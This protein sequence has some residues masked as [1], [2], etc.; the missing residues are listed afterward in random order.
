MSL[1][2][3][4]QAFSTA[5]HPQTDG[6]TE[7]VNRVMQ[8]V[9]RHYVNP[10][11]DDWDVWLPC[12]EFAI[13]NA[14]HS[15]SKETPFF[16]NYGVHPSTPLSLQSPAQ[17]AAR[18]QLPAALKFTADMHAAL[19]RAKR[20]LQAAQDRMRAHADKRRTELQLQVG[21]VVW[22][23]S[24]N[25]AVKHTGSRKL[26]PRRLGPFT[27]VQCINPVAYKLALPA[28]MSKVHPVFH[29]SLLTPYTDG[30]RVQ[31]APAPVVLAD[32]ALDYEVEAVIGHR[33]VGR[34]R[35]L[36]YLIKFKGYG[37][38]HNEWLP[39]ANL[40]CDDLV[41]E[42]LASA[43]YARSEDKIQRQQQK[44]RANAAQVAAR[45]VRKQPARAKRATR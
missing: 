23:D 31:P 34:G 10:T 18:S 28:T 41:Q 17:R 15:G 22:L 21:A 32:G 33:F 3:V 36:Q 1:L 38:E 43:A 30:G 2:Q 44:K 9:L 12:V 40:S 6:Q 37:H 11:Q 29:V 42:Y 19:D 45:P 7:R 27:V 14:V 35:K 24:K 39:P 4:E 16:L 13:N 26:L 25:I 8:E 20:C 5:Y